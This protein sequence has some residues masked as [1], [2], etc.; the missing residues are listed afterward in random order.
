MSDLM[1][2][3]L[4]SEKTPDLFLR[5]MNI[6]NDDYDSFL[7]KLPGKKLIFIMQQNRSCITKNW[8]KN[9]IYSKQTDLVDNFLSINVGEHRLYLLRFELCIK[10]LKWN[11]YRPYCFILLMNNK[12]FNWKF[13]QDV[14]SSP[15]LSCQRLLASNKDTQVQVEIS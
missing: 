15:H 4:C 14:L 2:I 10:F 11:I 13:W 5:R 3:L 6:L 7:M 8:R 1:V 9:V 12:C